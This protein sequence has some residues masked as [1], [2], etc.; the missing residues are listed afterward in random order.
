MTTSQTIEQQRRSILLAA[1]FGE[2][3][4]PKGAWGAIAP[5]L[6][7]GSQEIGFFDLL[8]KTWLPHPTRM[9]SAEYEKMVFQDRGK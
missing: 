4:M 1:G 2:D 7:I 3:G 6:P 9:D 8:T 5:D